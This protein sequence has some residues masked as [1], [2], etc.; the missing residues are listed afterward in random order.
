MLQF[1]GDGVWLASLLA[2]AAPLRLRSAVMK[3]HL[4]RWKLFITKTHV[5]MV[6]V[7]DAREDSRPCSQKY[8]QDIET[9]VDQNQTSTETTSTDP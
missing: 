5:V 6:R 2:A 3:E 9:F 4:N 7:K 1:S 8:S